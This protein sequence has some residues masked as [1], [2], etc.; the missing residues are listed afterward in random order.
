MIGLE[1]IFRSVIY[2]TDSEGRETVSQRN[3]MKN[4]RALQQHVPEAPAEKA[5]GI[6]YHFILD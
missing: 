3:L 4:F 2:V 1:T 5:W 6:L